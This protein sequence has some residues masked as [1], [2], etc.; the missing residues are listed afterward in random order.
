MQKDTLPQGVGLEYHH[1]SKHVQIA[2]E[3]IRDIEMLLCSGVHS[4]QNL[5]AFGKVYPRTAHGYHWAKETEM[6]DTYAN[7]ISLA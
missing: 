7:L 2:K 6:C 5:S 4:R 1:G 3:L